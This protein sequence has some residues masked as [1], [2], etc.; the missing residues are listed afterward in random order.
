VRGAAVVLL[1]DAPAAWDGWSV[2]G[3]REVTASLA[4]RSGMP[5]AA[6]R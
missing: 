4:P 2:T 1:T 6:P 5:A 3:L